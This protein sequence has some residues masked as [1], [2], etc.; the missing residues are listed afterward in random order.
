M[1]N[2]PPAPEPLLQ[3]PPPPPPPTTSTSTEL[4]PAGTVQLLVPTFV[5]I[6]DVF[7]AHFAYS[8]VSA[9]M[10]VAKLNGM[11]SPRSENHPANV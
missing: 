1:W 3:M 9:V 11:V 5:N 2:M 6:E 8:A 10:G 4:T 7:T